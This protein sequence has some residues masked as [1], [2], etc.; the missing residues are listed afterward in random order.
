MAGRF[1]KILEFIG[2]VDD[3]PDE[4]FDQGRNR[5]SGQTYGG[6]SSRRAPQPPP[7]PT[8]QGRGAP[9]YDSGRSNDRYNSSPRPDYE[10]RQRRDNHTQASP[11]YTSDYRTGSAP[12]DYGAAT[13][14]CG[15]SSY[16]L[17]RD[18]LDDE[19]E[20]AAPPR[21]TR[22]PSGQRANNV[23]SMRPQSVTTDH[24]TVIYYL[25]NLEECRDVINDLL[26][27]KSVLLNL[28]DMEERAVQRSID[29]LCGA[30][31]A[32]GAT[33]RKASDKTY[34]IAPNNVMVNSTNDEGRRY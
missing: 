23:V 27:S 30:A 12:N 16:R 2:L 28:E 20:R 10:A 4:E 22:E 31:F 1:N 5:P 32:L 19:F 6:S 33:L 21:A 26:D 3:E 17:T 34:L 8:R 24:Q 9:S 25:R 29:T 7:T 18:A 14:D 11:R 15:A 13:R